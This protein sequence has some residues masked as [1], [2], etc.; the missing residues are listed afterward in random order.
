MENCWSSSQRISRMFWRFAIMTQGC[1]SESCH[2]RAMALV[3]KNQTL[4][5]SASIRVVHWNLNRKIF[6][7][8]CF[9]RIP[10]NANSLSATN[11][12]RFKLGLRPSLSEAIF[13]NNNNR[14]TMFNQM[15]CRLEVTF[16]KQKLKSCRIWKETRHTSCLFE[17]WS[18]TDASVVKSFICIIV[19]LKLKSH[20]NNLP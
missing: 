1:I 20:I 18:T 6:I 13:Y 14:K 8:H 19:S 7:R 9:E 2:I 4:I 15:Q 5:I 10:N 17:I 16:A 12:S 3:S 11:C